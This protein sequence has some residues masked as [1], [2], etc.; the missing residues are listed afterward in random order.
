[1]NY[2]TVP[3]DLKSQSFSFPMSD[4]VKP[5][6]IHDRGQ[7]RHAADCAKFHAGITVKLKLS[8]V[9]LSQKVSA[10][11]CQIGLSQEKSTIVGSF[12]MQ[13]TVQSFMLA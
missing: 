4:R 5:R 13:Q 12:H 9:T 11:S 7:F 2:E 3:R 1:M 8:P 10:S 6:K